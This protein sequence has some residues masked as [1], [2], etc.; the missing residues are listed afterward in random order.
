MKKKS[1]LLLLISTVVVLTL[2]VSWRI[3]TNKRTGHFRHYNIR[4]L[5]VD[6]AIVVRRPMPIL[7]Q[8]VGQV[9]SEHSVQIR[10]QVSGM[11][12]RVF[13][14]EGQTVHTG[15]RLF[16]IDPAPYRAALVS[17]KSAWASAKANADRLAPLA[18]KDYVTPQ[19]YQNARTTA[20]QAKATYQQ[21]RINLAYTDI[22]SPI[23]GRTG[24]LT[25]KAGNVVAPSDSTPLVVINQMEPILVQYTIPQQQLDTLRHYNSLNTIKVMI[26]HEDGSGHLGTGKL[27]FIDNNVNNATGTV[28]L[29]A[30]IP[31]KDVTLWPGQYVGVNMQLTLQKNALVIP[32]SAVQTGQHGNFVY[33]IVNGKAEIASITVDRQIGSNAVIASGLK[34]GETVVSRVPRS[35][36]PGIR[37]ISNTAPAKGKP[38]R[39][40]RHE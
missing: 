13:F 19:E 4:P 11:L 2:L 34:S 36:R 25:V 3:S 14:T 27:V 8:S 23:S 20:D 33:R 15:Q 24:S 17:A 31:N 6:T 16:E 5:N 35:M 1:G 21:A 37:I 39:K 32:D 26:T 38:A 18:A 7:L 40:H 12:K 9:E 30:E 28:M 22:R 29:K 10:P